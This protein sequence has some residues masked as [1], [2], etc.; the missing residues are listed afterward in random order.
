ML[1]S[2]PRWRGALL[3]RGPSVALDH[4]VPALRRTVKKAAPRPGHGADGSPARL[5]HRLLQ[6]HFPRSRPERLLLAL[7]RRPSRQP[8]HV[9]GRANTAVGVGKA[10]AIELRHP[11]HG[12]AAG[13]NPPPFQK[14]VGR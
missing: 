7:M 6:P 4:W 9:E 8:D 14:N 11:Q 3:I 2:T 1:R 5:L 10:L 13:R 12:G